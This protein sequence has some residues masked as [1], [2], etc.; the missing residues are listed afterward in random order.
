MNLTTTK[1]PK[2]FTP[3]RLGFTLIELLV[4]IAIIAILASILFPVFAQAREKARATT[5]LSNLKQL[6]LGFEMY[7]QDYDGIYPIN[8]ERTDADP[9]TSDAEET[10]AWPELI[11][12]YIK[13]GKVINPDGTVS[14]TQG[15]YHCPSDSGKIIG[16]SYA[17]NSWLEFGFSESAINR[18]AETIVIAEKRGEIEEEHFT[19]WLAPWP[20][21]PLA[22]NTSIDLTEEAINNIKVS[23]P[24]A[25]HEVGL[26]T[27]RHNKGANWLYADSHVKW[28]NLKRVWGDATTT[29]QLWPVRP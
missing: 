19:W 12:S 28:S 6:G 21:W 29:N 26:Q 16:P 17:I 9:P 15:V 20:T 10:I 3:K 4:V 1:A 23:S 7:K 27:R 2:A 14:Y 5:C 25:E 18:P 8:R 13:S 22:Q 24:A 11:E